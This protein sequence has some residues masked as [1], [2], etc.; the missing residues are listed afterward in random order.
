MNPSLP[1]RIFGGVSFLRAALFL[2]MTERYLASAG[3]TVS[4]DTFVL[5]QGLGVTTLCLGILAWRAPDIA[6][7]ALNA[8]GQLFGIVLAIY[9]AFLG[10][11]IVTG[12]V[13]GTTVYVL[14]VVHIALAAMFFM[15]SKK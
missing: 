1:F 8:F 15:N 6:G 9:V 7:N 10:Y 12:T 5:A 2:F 14:I 3:V 13:S 4:S 11:N